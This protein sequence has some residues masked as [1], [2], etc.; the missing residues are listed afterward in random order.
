M[1]S[2]AGT[3]VIGSLFFLSFPL[4]HFRDILGYILFF[5]TS[6]TTGVITKKNKNWNVV[7]VRLKCRCTNRNRTIVWTIVVCLICTKEL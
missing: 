4:E 5:H 6:I 1:R 2:M 3:P 7:A